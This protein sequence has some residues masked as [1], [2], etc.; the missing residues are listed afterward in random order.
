MTK[1]LI[2]MLLS[3]LIGTSS[4]CV[5]SMPAQSRGFIASPT[6][7]IAVSYDDYDAKTQVQQQNQVEE[8]FLKA[9]ENFASKTSAPLLSGKENACYSPVSLYFALSLSAAGA[10]GTT[11]QQ[12]LSLL[13]VKDAASLTDS[14]AKL[15][16]R[17]YTDNE[18][19][20]LKIANSLWMADH[21][22][23]QP[24]TFE[25]N[26]LN[27]ATKDFYASLYTGDL[28]ADST[29]S[30]MAQWVKDNTGGK[31]TPKFQA[32]PL[33]LLYL[34]NT[35][36]FKDQWLDQFSESGNTVN[37]FHLADGTTMDATFMHQTDS[38][39][40]SHGS[41]YTT[42]GL[43]LRN[44]GAIY[45]VLPDEGVA[46]DSL[47]TAERLPEIFSSIS[48]SSTRI[49]W[50]VPKFTYH[51]NLNLKEMLKSSG[52][53]DIFDENRADLSNMTKTAAYLSN[54]KQQTYIALDENGVEAAAY[55]EL[56]FEATSAMPIEEPIEFTLDR[57]FLYFIT[58]N[59]NTPLFIGV[60]VQ[61]TA[62]K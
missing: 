36:Y 15:Y 2:S 27:T 53:T 6:Y 30:D 9:V 18:I 56:S 43:T 48:G 50:S 40:I 26:F 59:D 29:L 52:V 47:L 46:L 7:P 57:P 17:L 24:V 28:T 32:D 16:R 58:S 19:G 10:H 54:A 13:G 5:P 22:L 25:T 20:S 44:N 37:T 11:Q 3:T 49:T 14:C 61:P 55:T 1:Q 45:F 41:G 34:M 62:A 23:G 35:I 38:S 31:I 33:A 4:M 42:A 8:S 51:T 12:L 60:C 21:I 39:A